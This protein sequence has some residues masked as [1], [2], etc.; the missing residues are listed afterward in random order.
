MSHGRRMDEMSGQLAVWYRRRAQLTGA[1]ITRFE[2]PASGVVNETYLHDVTYTRGGKPAAFS[3]VLRVQPATRDTPIPN[4]DVHQQAFVLRQLAKV[5]GL[6]TPGVLWDEPDPQWL[7]R[8]FYV[9]EA[10][11]GDA[12]FDAGDI[13]GDADTLQLMYE[14]TIAMLV[15][16]HAVD[17]RRAGLESLFSGAGQQAPLRAQLDSYRLHLN[18]AS[19]GK[20]YPLLESALDYLMENV[21]EESAPVLNWGDARIGNLL[22]DGA[23]LTAVLDWEIAEVSAREVDV[24]WFLF[25]ERFFRK[26]GVDERPGAWSEQEI[27]NLYQKLAGVELHNL[28]YFQRWAAFRLAVMRLR[29]GLFAIRSGLEPESSRVDEVNFGS[30]E[31]ARVFGYP[32]PV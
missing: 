27:I 12:V 2:T 8:P 30:V 7:G 11:R 3:A 6:P 26:D 22:F 23:E 13:P 32:E 31:L 20:G 4:V 9:M 24:G 21:P 10:M 1:R 17:W 16:I 18:N 14:Q 19:V 5:D 28:A 25:F 15:R 29:A